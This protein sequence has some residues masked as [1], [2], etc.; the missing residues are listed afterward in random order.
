MS[1]ASPTTLWALL[2]ITGIGT[3]VL[4]LSFIGLQGRADPPEGWIKLLRYVPASV[5]SALVVGAVLLHEGDRIT[6]GPEAGAAV[7]AGVVAWR[8]RNVVAT[9]V[10]G[11]LALWMIRGLL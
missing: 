5:L 6:L 1:A 7:L 4:R 10:A 11:M 9:I 2:V 8:T 3:F